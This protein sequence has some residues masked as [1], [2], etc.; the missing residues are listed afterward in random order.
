M[1]TAANTKFKAE[2]GLDVVGSAN[3]S[4]SIRVEGDVSIGGNVATALYVTGNVV[5]VS[6]NTYDLGSTN[7]RWGLFANTASL[8][9]A[10]T[11]LGA[12]TLNTVTS[13]AHL[14]SGNNIALGGATKRWAIWANT[15]DS[16]SANVSGNSYFAN[17]VVTNTITIGV[18]VANQTHLVMT[19][20]AN[21]TVSINTGSKVAIFTT[22]NTS[23][24]NLVLTNDVTT[25]AGNV[26]FDTDLLFLDSVNNRVGIKTTSPSTSAMVTL[27]GN[28]EFS[29]VNTGIRLNTSNTTINGHI[30][31]SG[32]TTV[33]RALFNI[34][35]GSST[36]GL[37]SG[38][39][40]FTASG[41]GTATFNALTGVANT[42]EIITTVSAHTFAN[43]DIVTYTVSTG[44]TA[45][46]GLVSGTSYY[47]VNATSGGSTLQLSATLGGSA[48]G[49]TAGLSQVGHTLAKT[50]QTL[51]NFS[52]T[53]FLYK[54][55]N[56][57]HS[58]NFGIYN[59]SGTR[60]GP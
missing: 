59:V 28:L 6:N 17:V 54:Q 42:T 8:T 16:L 12:T 47:V 19:G 25:I 26:V 30:Q 1:A 51:V 31:L 37:Q 27:S 57:A 46:T 2:N 22:G 9:G 43:T 48:L 56:V 60:V 39:Y 7:M 53:T 58:G 38:G 44:N 5:P 4:G 33:G 32:N 11:V 49:L 13:E 41:T 21:G 29:D 55:G 3:V 15:I 10:L 52:N 36:A 50:T 35:D 23:Y 34:W 24:S 45:I 18:T 14:P 40:Y 20:T